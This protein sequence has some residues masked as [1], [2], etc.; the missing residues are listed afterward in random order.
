MSKV[1]GIAAPMTAFAIALL[2]ATAAFAQGTGLSVDVSAVP[3]VCENGVSTVTVSYTVTS[4]GAADG[5]T[6]GYTVNGGTAVALP[7][8][9]GGIAPAGG[10]TQGQGSTKTASGQFQLQLPSGEYDIEVCAEQNGADKK[11]GCDD[12]H[13]QIACQELEGCDQT[14]T[15]FGEIVGNKNLCQS[16]A[17]VN[18]HV[19]GLFGP[20]ATVDVRNANNT[21][22]DS[23]QVDRAGDSCVYHWNLDPKTW[24]DAIAGSYTLTVTGQNGSTTTFSANLSCSKPG[25]K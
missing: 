7:S 23:K 6:V 17:R 3:G 14:A 13:V 25:K 21:L 8:I 5:A 18:V 9:A 2:G 10:W 15:L 4:T 19:K 22:V 20:W 16:D 11:S 12:V 1:K 24:P